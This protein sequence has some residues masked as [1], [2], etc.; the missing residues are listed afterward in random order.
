MN[1]LRSGRQI[2]LA[3]GSALLLASILLVTVV[4]PAEYGWDPTGTGKAMG[5]LDMS[6]AGNSPLS[7]RSDPSHS[8]RIEFQLAPFEAVEYKYHLEAGATLLFQWR[9]NDELL[10][11]MHAEPEG[12]A[13]GYAQ[14]FA[15]SR[16]SE[17]NG[18]Y[19]APFTGIHGWFWQN[20]TQQDITL[21]LRTNGFYSEAVE[22]RDGR[23]FHYD[24]S[25][26]KS[27][28]SQP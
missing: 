1:T 18:T 20:R 19:T 11:D 25:T 2:A 3:S 10:Y 6:Q 16:A 24:F 8:D 26:P 9:A 22:M 27:A 17:S 23:E 12:A 5:L 15:K 28:G 13:P 4:L 14:S 7:M 21:T